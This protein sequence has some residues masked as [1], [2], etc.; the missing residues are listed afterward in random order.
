[1]NKSKN[2]SSVLL[3]NIFLIL[4]VLLF[5]EIYLKISTDDWS[6]T[7]NLGIIR[8]NTTI[9]KT[10]FYG[11]EK[12]IIYSRDK[13][14]LRD[15]C[16]PKEIDILT[17]G[18]STTDQRYIPLEDTFQAILEKKL[19]IELGKEI[20]VSN[21]GV[22]G[23]STYAH[24]A[25][26]EIW[27]PLIKD[28]N[29]D[30]YLLFIGVNDAFFIGEDKKPINLEKEQDS[31][32]ETF[33]Q[34]LN[35]YKLYIRLVKIVKGELIDEQYAGHSS[36]ELTQDKYTVS[37]LNTATEKLSKDN[38][39]QFRK[40]LKIIINK[41]RESESELL[42]VTQPHRFVIENNGNLFGVKDIFSRGE[43]KFSGLDY[44]YSLKEINKVIFEECSSENTI[45][46]YSYNFNET[47]FYDYAHTT[48]EGSSEIGLEI[49]NNFKQLSIFDSLNK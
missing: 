21:A 19:S 28:L 32:K 30:V 35:L 36:I 40:R 41:I 4:V 33:I 18:G 29:P 2:L 10:N 39:E 37:N 43:L 38:A 7:Q 3:I 6:E 26:F 9:F 48:P 13:Y 5:A 16:D 24:I 31:K 22:D 49:F 34:S 12:E 47:H 14:G 44:D 17:I 11:D 23:H 1:M 27:F 8:D 25:S 45:D 46:L 42:C 20:C 15:N